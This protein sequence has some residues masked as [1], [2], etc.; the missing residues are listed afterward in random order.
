MPHKGTVSI[1]EIRIKNLPVRHLCCGHFL[2]RLVQCSQQ[3]GQSRDLPP[4]AK[5]W[6]L[7]A[8]P[9]GCSIHPGTIS[10]LLQL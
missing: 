9:G 3:S 10:S 4:S 6:L 7:P 1:P 8:L 5:A 2:L